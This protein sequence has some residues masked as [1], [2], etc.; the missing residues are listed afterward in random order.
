MHKAL[1][2][3]R[4]RKQIR[5]YL[6]ANG[7]KTMEIRQLAFLGKKYRTT[8]K[9]DLDLVEKLLESYEREKTK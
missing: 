9:A 2:S 5:V 7:E 3:E 1:L 6:K 4:E 8:M